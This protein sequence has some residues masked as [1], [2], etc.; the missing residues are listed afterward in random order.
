MNGQM[1]NPVVQQ[2]PKTQVLAPE[3]GITPSLWNQLSPEHRKQLAQQ[4]AKMIQQIRQVPR[5]EKSCDERV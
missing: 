1:A 2:Q 5:Q 3:N 4:L